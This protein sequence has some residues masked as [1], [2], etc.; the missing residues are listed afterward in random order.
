MSCE[1]MFMQKGSWEC[2]V[3]RDFK[4]FPG[5]SFDDLHEMLLAINT[6]SKS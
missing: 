6:V 1:R 5:T 2:P 3:E 4:F